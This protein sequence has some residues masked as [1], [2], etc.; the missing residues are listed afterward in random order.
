MSIPIA[1]GS[2]RSGFG[3]QLS[4][5]CDSG[6]GNGSFG[7]GW[8][9]LFPPI[10]RKTDKGIPRYHNTEES[11]VFALSRSVY[12]REESTIAEYIIKL[13]NKGGAIERS[14]KPF[15]TPIK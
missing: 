7:F 15:V 8:N 6:A 13:E 12:A 11:D 4:L 2:G 1:T 9:L 5:S 14:V 10:T 3:P